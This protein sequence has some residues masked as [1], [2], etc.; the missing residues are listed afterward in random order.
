MNK[1]QTVLDTLEKIACLGNGD[2]HGNS[3][4]N[5]LA[6]EVIAIVKEMMQS[7]PVAE[8]G[9]STFTW[10][11]D[12]PPAGTKLYTHAAPQAV[13]A[14]KGPWQAGVNRQDHRVY[15]QSD[16]FKHDVRLYVDGDFPTKDAAYLYAC[17]IARQ[18]NAAA[19]AVKDKP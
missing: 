3:V 4:G 5:V 7:E 10:L 9:V 18:L 8:L 1:L 19:S 2:K 17:G 16:D 11:A 15:I 14:D 6:I 13:P 12:R